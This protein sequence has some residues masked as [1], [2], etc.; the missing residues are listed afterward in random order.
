M[1]VQRL[2]LQSGGCMTVPRERPGLICDQMTGAQDSDAS[3]G[4]RVMIMESASGI[5]PLAE[6]PGPFPPWSGRARGLR[7]D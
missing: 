3:N 6:E 4:K 7:A 2:M 5:A 1:D